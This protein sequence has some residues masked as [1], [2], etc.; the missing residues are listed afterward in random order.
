MPVFLIDDHCD[1][2]DHAVNLV[3][4]ATSGVECGGRSP[5]WPAAPAGDC[6]E[7]WAARSSMLSAWAKLVADPRVSGDDL[8]TESEGTTNALRCLQVFY[9]G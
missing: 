2:S 8:T 9:R 7:F 5:D 3:E 1:E 6:A 4:A